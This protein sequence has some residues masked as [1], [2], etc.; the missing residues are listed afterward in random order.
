MKPLR[1]ACQARR[2]RVGKAHAYYVMCNSPAEELV[3][4]GEPA[5][6]WVG[7]D[8]RGVELEMLLIEKPDVF[9]VIHVMPTHLRERD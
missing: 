8:D 7:K 5:L 1:F 2:H 4:R 6:K 9:L 3:L